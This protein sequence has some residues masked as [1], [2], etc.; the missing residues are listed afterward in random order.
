MNFHKFSVV[1]KE[2]AIEIRNSELNFA[3]RVPLVEF[4]FNGVLCIV[5]H[6]TNLDFLFRDYINAGTMDWGVVGPDCVEKYSDT[7]QK[8]LSGRQREAEERAKERN[9][10]YKIEA[11][12]KLSDL[13]KKINGTQFECSNLEVLKEYEEKNSDPYG[14]RCVSY[15]KE[16]ALLMQVG[17]KEGRL[18]KDIAEQTSHEADYDGIS[19]FMYGASVSILSQC[20]K[21][22]EELRKWHNKEYNH[23]G[24]GVANPAIL[25]ISK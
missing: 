6:K 17:I 14:A 22:G 19:G 20:W 10:Q 5:S 7:V 21:H 16:W 24:N 2:R 18:V 4:E 23:E 1:A 13:N 9:R 25:T 8:E 12:K 3:I 15:A 11:D